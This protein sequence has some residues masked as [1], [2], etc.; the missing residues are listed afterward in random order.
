MN[1]TRALVAGWGTRLLAA[2][3]LAVDAAVHASIAGQYDAVT[4][5]ISEGTLFRV[6]AVAAA[7]AALLVLLRLHWIGDLFAGATA[8]AGLVAIV[9]YR[10]V[11]VGGFGPFP[12][13]YEPIWSPAKW[14]VV[15]GTA[16]ALLA[17]GWRPQDR[18]RNS[19][20]P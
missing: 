1:D 10:Y 3:G 12:D 11:D 6:E 8:L 5:G 14:W 18:H 20:A 13:M 7:L 19:H 15:G 17:L 4:A 2:L 16:I 9:L